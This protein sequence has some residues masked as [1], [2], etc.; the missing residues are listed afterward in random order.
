MEEHLKVAVHVACVSLVDQAHISLLIPY[1]I[2]FSQGK[3]DEKIRMHLLKFDPSKFLPLSANFFPHNFQ[4][5]IRDPII[6]KPRILSM[7]IDSVLFIL[8]KRHG[9][10][11]PDI[12]GDTEL[13]IHNLNL[14][15]ESFSSSV[16]HTSK[17]LLVEPGLPYL[18]HH[19]ACLLLE[20]VLNLEISELITWHTFR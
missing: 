5:L 6:T 20:E 9:L 15:Q 3:V 11:H 16:K 2:F 19:F 10:M 18:N 4:S 14:K 7:N 8:F 13:T 17:I 12:T 1:F